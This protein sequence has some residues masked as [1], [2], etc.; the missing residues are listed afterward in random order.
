[1]A[2]YRKEDHDLNQ[3]PRE[4]AECGASVL[5]RDEERHLMEDCPERQVECL[6]CHTFY[7]AKNIDTHVCEE[8]TSSCGDCKEDVADTAMGFHA[9][10]LCSGCYV[11]CFECDQEVTTGSMKQHKKTACTGKPRPCPFGCGQEVSPKLLQEHLY[12]SKLQ[13]EHLKA[14]QEQLE[15]TTSK[16]GAKLRGTLDGSLDE[17]DDEEKAQHH[18]QCFLMDPKGFLRAGRDPQPLLSAENMTNEDAV[19]LGN[20][21]LYGIEGNLLIADA[22]KAYEAYG[23]ADPGCAERLVAQARIQ[24]DG[25][26]GV[27]EN[28]EEAVRKLR[29][30]HT[31]GNEEA[32]Y[33]LAQCL[34]KGDGC[35]QDRQQAKTILKQI[36]KLPQAKLLLANLMIE[37]GDEVNNAKDTIKELASRLFYPPACI[38]VAKDLLEKAKRH[39]SPRQRAKLQKQAYNQLKPAAFQGHPE[40][41]LLAADALLTG[42]G[43]AKNTSLGVK[44]ILK[45]IAQ[46]NAEA[47]YVLAGYLERGDCLPSDQDRAVRLYAE[48]ATLGHPG[49][50]HKLA[51]A[52]RVGVCAP[53]CLA[54]AIKWLELCVSSG[55]GPE[56]KHDLAGVLTEGKHCKPDLPRAQ[57]LLE[58][59]A[60]AGHLQSKYGFAVTLLSD[61]D[62]YEA[63][64]ARALQ[65][66]HQAS[67]AGLMKANVL[68]GDLC[69]EGIKVERDAR[70]AL[71]YYSKVQNPSDTLLAKM[72]SLRASIPVEGPRVEGDEEEEDVIEIV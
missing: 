41:L 12:N 10:R 39:P 47:M 26:G 30:A 21:F 9:V 55:G 45:S 68:L 51:A 56:A 60:G 67:A 46:G 69:L 54:E 31:A 13:K 7:P 57:Q 17:M 27:P 14:S 72:Q 15:Q 6:A 66:L 22:K 37:D 43:I 62:E 52:F 3:C 33:L 24:L 16:A 18:L 59:A 70:Q 23:K 36:K 19:A 64:T 1:M 48:A 61:N 38:R 2:R 28:K 58:Q 63:D 44:Y 32:K 49:A 65:N 40:G 8:R 35:Q 5:N 42:T 29:A 53:K 11:E 71:Y 25:S 20:L 50:M 34:L 4:C